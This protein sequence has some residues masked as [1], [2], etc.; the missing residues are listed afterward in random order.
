MLLFSLETSSFPYRAD[1]GSENPAGEIHGF[2]YVAAGTKE[3]IAYLGTACQCIKK[4]PLQQREGKY[5]QLAWTAAL[6]SASVKVH[7]KEVTL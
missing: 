7:R 5:H 2:P 3:F 1:F 6:A 4:L